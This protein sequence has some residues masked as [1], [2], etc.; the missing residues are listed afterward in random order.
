MYSYPERG[1]NSM[2][3]AQFNKL[4][5]SPEPYWRESAKLS[6]FPTLNTN[7]KTGVCVVGGGITGITTA[8]QLVQEGLKVILV[9]ADQILNGTTGHTTAKITAQHV[10]FMM[11]SFSTLERKRRNFI[12]RQTKKLFTLL[13]SWLIENGLS[14]I[15][16]NRMRIFIPSRNKMTKR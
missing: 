4:P 9:D 5:K 1:G 11:S 10:L 2:N 15:L 8:Y 16:V 3:E 6:S 7:K 12:T 14:V 13:K